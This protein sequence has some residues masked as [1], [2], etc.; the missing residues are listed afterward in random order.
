MREN[1]DPPNPDSRWEEIERDRRVVEE[2]LDAV[3][4]DIQLVPAGTTEA[5]QLH[6]EARRLGDEHQRLGDE[7]ARIRPG[8]VRHPRAVADIERVRERRRI[9]LQILAVVVPWRDAFP[10]MYREE[11]DLFRVRAHALLNYLDVAVLPYPDLRE[12]LADAKKE[13]AWEQPR[14]GPHPVH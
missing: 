5:G 8:V 1:A 6:D 2:H 13:L 7:A 12:A 10:D 14:T 4:R 9:G 3:M 11:C